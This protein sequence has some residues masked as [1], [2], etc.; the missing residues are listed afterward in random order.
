MPNPTDPHSHPLFNRFPLAADVQLSTGPAP[1]P[2]HVYDGHAALVGGTAN[3]QIVRSLL[4][5]EE[6]HPVVTRSGRALAALWVCDFQDASLGPHL[7]LQVSFFTSRIP[8]DPV[9]EHPFLILKLLAEEAPAGQSVQMFCHAL[10]NDREPVVAYNREHLG[11]PAMLAA[12]NVNR[13]LRRGLKE[14]HFSTPEG[15]RLVAGTL[16]EKTRTPLGAAASLSRLLGLTRALQLNRQP[17]LE[18]EVANP[19]SAAFP[20][21]GTAHTYLSFDRAVLH[22]FDPRREQLAFGPDIYPGLDFRPE[23]VEHMLGIKFVYGEVR[24]PTDGM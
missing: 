23:Q 3:V 18:A 22:T 21:N 20:F 24:T 16:L 7:E 10:W 13:D 4:Q 11:L 12:G 15:A 19:R 6:L 5:E 17:W 8:L 9:P 2:Y 14:F 1:T